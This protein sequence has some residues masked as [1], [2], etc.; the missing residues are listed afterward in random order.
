MKRLS[1]WLSSLCLATLCACVGDAG[2]YT[3]SSHPLDEECLCDTSL[4]S[5]NGMLDVSLKEAFV[6]PTYSVG[7]TLQ[8]D[9]D[10]ET[11]DTVGAQRNLFYL[12]QM[13]LET[14]IGNSTISEEMD[15]SGV[16]SPGG[17]QLIGVFEIISPKAFQKMSQMASDELQSAVVSIRFK[18]K[19]LSGSDYT[20]NAYDFPISFYA[21]GQMPIL[22]C[23]EEGYVLQ[24]TSGSDCL[25]L[26]RLGEDGTST[27][28]VPEEDAE[29]T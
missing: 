15:I 10:G 16:C 11:T 8:N 1:C 4:I 14:R 3:L 12:R 13:I 21:S 17:G 6:N 29:S 18:G 19:L 22:E 9:L 25:S 5:V 2:I 20:T 28:C 26:G 7:L 27:T 23:E 24:I